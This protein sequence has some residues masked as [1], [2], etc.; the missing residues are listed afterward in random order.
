MLEANWPKQKESKGKFFA[1][2]SASEL[3]MIIK[4]IKQTTEHIDSESKRYKAAQ[5]KL[6]NSTKIHKIHSQN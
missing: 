2:I 6:K 4:N 3:G 1:E 5:L